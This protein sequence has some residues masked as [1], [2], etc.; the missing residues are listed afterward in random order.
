VTGRRAD[1][2]HDLDT[3]VAFADAG[4]SIR[5]EEAEGLTLAVEGAFA[6]H[7]PEGKGNL[8]HRAAA[9]LRAAAGIADGAAIRVVKAV[10]AGAGLGGG[11]SEAAATL[12]ALNR[13]WGLG[14]SLEDLARL[15]LPLG[16]DLPM[17]VRARPLR[18]RGVGEAIEPF[19][20]PPLPLVLAWPGV[21]SSTPEIF[22]RL[23]SRSNPPLPEPPV[24]ASA[25]DAARYLGSCRNDLE[26][27]AIAAL[28]EI[29]AALAALR[30]LPGALLARMTGS[31]AACFALF[32]TR[33]E[34][35][36]AAATLRAARPGWWVWAGVTEAGAPGRLPL[37]RYPY[38]SRT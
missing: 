8:V 3:L 16:A 7:A 25:A 20:L 29:G 17:C 1:G 34:A 12:R 2:Y 32:A 23:E 18:A 19:D 6:A 38:P 13:L 15:G 37:P 5:V 14:L 31:G 35:E 4:A 30:A 9:A 11:S 36:A 22:R 28:A 21:P 24:L 27:P 10:P 33:G 26:G